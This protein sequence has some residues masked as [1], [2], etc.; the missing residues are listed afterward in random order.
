MHGEEYAMQLYNTKQHTVRWQSR[1]MTF[2]TPFQDNDR[3]RLRVL[4]KLLAN[5]LHFHI[6]SAD[7]PTH[8]TEV[9]NYRYKLDNFP[10]HIPV[11]GIVRLGGLEVQKV[12]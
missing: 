3:I 6:L 11:L 7:T 5:F 2:H 9:W 8:D 4:W 1:A 12:L 10:L